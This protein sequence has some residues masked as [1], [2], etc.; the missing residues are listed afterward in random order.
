MTALYLAIGIAIGLLVG[1]L[2]ASRQRVIAETRLEELR[3]DT[4]WTSRLLAGDVA[5]K[6]EFEDLV[7]IV[8]GPPPGGR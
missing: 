6:R 7:K 2:W 1:W 4:G 3:K 8:V 5:T